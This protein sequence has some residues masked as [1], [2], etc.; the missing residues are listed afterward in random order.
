MDRAQESPLTLVSAPAGYGKS[1]LVSHWAESQDKPCAWLS[2]DHED[3][4]LQVFVRYVLAAIETVHPGACRETRTLNSA[5]NPV[6][7]PIV[8]GCLANELECIDSPLVLVLDDC[9]RIDPKSDV[10]RFLEFLLEHMPRSLRLV[11]VTRTDPPFFIISLRAKGL[12]TEIRLREL[13]FTESECSEYLAR[14]SVVT[15][16]KEALQSLE[17]QT[18]GWVVALRLTTLYLSYVDDPEEFLRGMHGGI[19]YTREFLLLEVLT[20]L[21]PRLISA[22]L[23]TAILDRFCSQLCEAL[24]WHGSETD[25]PGFDGRQFIETLLADNLFIIP[26][27][28]QNSWFRYHHLFQE[29]LLEQ[30]E[31]RTDKEEV[32][33][34]HR[35]ASE[36][37]ETKGLITESIE[38]ARAAGDAERA[39]EITERNRIAELN[40]YRWYEVRKWLEMIPDACKQQRPGLQLAVAWILFHRKRRFSPGSVHHALAGQSA[41]G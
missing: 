2:L 12:V 11:L 26:L 40:A 33:V 41:G 32:A 31:V 38:H 28:E 15:V 25:D 20:R 9:H 37:F 22:L 18:E 6:P 14:S 8:G 3:S 23:K 5:P 17:Q 27:D 16:S 21:P 36:W 39:A 24:C 30:L 10:H 34:L 19:Q 1:T 35:R 29:M 4:D 7:I 13:K